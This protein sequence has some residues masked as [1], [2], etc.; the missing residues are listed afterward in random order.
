MSPI[1]IESIE[2]SD[3]EVLETWERV[4]DDRH[5]LGVRA[6]RLPDDSWPWQLFVA[7]TEVL[8]H[9]PLETQVSTAITESIGAV[10]GVDCVEREEPGL[11]VVAGSVA[12]RDLV[13]AVAT[14]VDG[15]A[16]EARKL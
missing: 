1:Q 16:F 9:G 15:F 5:L 3:P 13:L 4:T 7:M 12:G 6:I 11:W 14:V 2:T 10:A 8:G